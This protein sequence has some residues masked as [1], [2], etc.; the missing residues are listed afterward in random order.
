V[1][2]VKDRGDLAPAVRLLPTFTCPC[3]PQGLH[4]RTESLGLRRQPWISL[5]GKSV[6]T[7]FRV[8]GF[9][10]IVHARKFDGPRKNVV[11][12][13][14]G[15]RLGQDQ[16]HPLFPTRLGRPELHHS[17]GTPFLTSSIELSCGVDS[18]AQS[19]CSAPRCGRS[20]LT[21][22]WLSLKSKRHAAV[23]VLQATQTALWPLYRKLAHL[24]YPSPC[25]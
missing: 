11:H 6:L 25:D 20:L 16:I 23:S 18:V 5:W 1:N 19:R 12:L 8:W 15:G 4:Q 24:S 9:V 3:C 14:N 13:P 21:P 7:L 10:S 22:I 17:F 2:L